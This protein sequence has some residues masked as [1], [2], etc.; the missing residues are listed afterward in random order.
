MDN[1]PDKRAKGEREVI[2]G[3]F[4]LGEERRGERRQSAA[5]SQIQDVDFSFFRV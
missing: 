3:S 2:P 1:A 5:A 4:L